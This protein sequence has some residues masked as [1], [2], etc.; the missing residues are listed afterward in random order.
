M[1]PA[2]PIDESSASRV[3][4]SPGPAARRVGSDVP[5]YAGLIVLASGGFRIGWR[6]Y[7]WGQWALVINQSSV[8][9]PIDVPIDV[10]LD[11]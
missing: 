6:L 3:P 1:I 5:F 10:P 9:V 7:V 4:Q 11:V 2:T 8:N